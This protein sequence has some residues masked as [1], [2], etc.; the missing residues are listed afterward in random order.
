MSG[1]RVAFAS[2]AADLLVLVCFA[3]YREQ[4]AA[5]EDEKPLAPSAKKACTEAAS[6]DVAP[7]TDARLLAQVVSALGALASGGD[8]AMLNTFITQ[9][10]PTVLADVVL[11][12]MEHLPPLP[13]AAA[14]HAGTDVAMPGLAALFSS[15]AAPPA[16]VPPPAVAHMARAPDSDTNLTQLAGAAVA[17][18]PPAPLVAQQLGSDA[19]AAQ[20]RAA[21]ARI[22]RGDERKI[23]TGVVL[24]VAH[25]RCVCRGPPMTRAAG[26]RSLRRRCL[27]MRGARACRG[28]HRAG[29]RRGAAGVSAGR[30]LRPPGA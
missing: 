15:A 1:A 14:A 6:G 26:V 9:L 23:V 20:R 24:C 7:A 28:S 5:C 29:L 22:L 27:S 13:P 4:D 18:A 19:R 30:L 25:S 21:A 11:V 12:N 2:M 10:H 16:P 3:R 17:A 8:L